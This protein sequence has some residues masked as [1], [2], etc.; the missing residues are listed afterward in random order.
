MNSLYITRVVLSLGLIVSFYAFPT[1]SK[2]YRNYSYS[3]IKNSC[4]ALIIEHGDAIKCKYA[5]D[6]VVRY[7]SALNSEVAVKVL[8]DL[9]KEGKMPK[10]YGYEINN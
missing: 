4:L 3:C 8:K 9:I 7:I 10:Q 1:P 5:A 2:M 6:Q